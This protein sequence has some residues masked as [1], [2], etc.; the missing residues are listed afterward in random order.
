MKER[1]STGRGRTK[2]GKKPAQK[3]AQIKIPYTSGENA[4]TPSPAATRL[5]RAS[6]ASKPRVSVVI[7]SKNESE[8]LKYVL[9]LLPKDIYEVIIVDAS[10]NDSTKKTALSLTPKAKVIQQL[11]KG[12]GSALSAGFSY[13][14]GD[15]IVMLDADGSMDPREIPAYI[16]LL[17]SGADLVKGSRYIQG[18]HSEDITLLRS[19][20]N[21]AL[22]TIA[23]TLFKQRWSELA[24]GY[25]AFWRD[26]VKPLGLD[27][28]DHPYSKPRMDYGHGFEIETLIFTRA[29]AAGLR[30]VEAPSVEYNRVNGESNLRTF[31]DGF[32]VLLCMLQEY[33][34]K[35]TVNGNNQHPRLNPDTN[36]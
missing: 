3:P 33:A 20:G 29:A 14:T 1:K 10:D 13:A 21:Q 18:A 15:V 7:P 16:G 27:S 34:R 12:K 9:P 22:R 30:V 35:R 36:G 28:L 32:R 24:Y 19:I 2:A 8:N 25:A 11:G 6:R 23:N 26:I 4:T 5:D 17:M 31:P